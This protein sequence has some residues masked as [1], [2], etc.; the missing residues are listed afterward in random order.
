MLSE[1]AQGLRWIMDPHRLVSSP[2]ILEEHR[3]TVVT[4]ITDEARRDV[5]VE[6]RYLYEDRAERRGREEVVD[7]EVSAR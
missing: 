2:W 1:Q 5:T 6:R 4:H 7:D 3:L